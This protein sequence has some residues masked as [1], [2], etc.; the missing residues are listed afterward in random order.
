M[1]LI[2]A[3]I[4]HNVDINLSSWRPINANGDRQRLPMGTQ[5]SATAADATGKPG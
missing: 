4:N 3:L 5:Q 2:A 1:M